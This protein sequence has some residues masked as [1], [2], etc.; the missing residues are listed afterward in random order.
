[1][2]AVFPLVKKYGGAVIALTLDENGIPDNADER[3]KIAEKIIKTAK[4]YGIDKKDIIVDPLAMTISSDTTN[5][6]VTLESVR[7]IR[8]LGV[9]TSLGV[10][11]ISFGLPNRSVINSTF[12]AVAMENGLNLAIMNPFSKEMTDAY[13]AFCAVKNLD[14]NCSEFIEYSTQNSEET[15]TNTRKKEMTLHRSI[16][17][18][19]KESAVNQAQILL[20]SEQPLN[21]INN[22]IIPALNEIG[23]DFEKQKAFLPQL[24][25]SAEAA[26]AAFELLKTKM[27]TG[28]NDTSRTVVLAT[29]KGDIHDIG[30]N[31]VKVLLES[32]GFKVLDLGKDVPPE[33]V[34]KCAVENNCKLVGLSAL[35]TTTLPSMEETI[36]LLNKT[37]KSIKVIV[38]GAVLTKDYAKM[39]NADYY[40]ADAMDT[41]RIAEK[42]Y[43]K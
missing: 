5:A 13:Y 19:A 22:Y 42:F 25:L 43:S 39:I 18:G 26:S 15:K 34:V 31:I 2:E 36:K 4:Q 37:D 29:V 17:K 27:N 1:M 9:Y 14:S 38:G 40:G 6:L 21:I 23:D 33:E 8:A 11:N 20:E 35:M 3:V 28:D 24:L 7:K 16:V 12:F 32:Y 10:S 41:V 30:K